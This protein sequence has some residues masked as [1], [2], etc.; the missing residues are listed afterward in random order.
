MATKKKSV[1]KK[2][3]AVDRVKL[4][5][6]TEQGRVLRAAEFRLRDTEFTHQWAIADW[7]LA[8]VEAFGK[9]KAYKA[10]M[11]ATGMTEQTLD[12]FAHTARK[13]LTRVKGVSFGHHRLV[14]KFKG[15][16]RKTQQK[17]QL[18]Y[19]KDNN[20]SVAEFDLYLKGDAHIDAQEKKTPTNPDVVAVKF[21]KSCDDLL[22][23][24]GLRK[25]LSSAP[26]L[27]EHRE[28]LVIKLKETARQLNEAVDGLSHQWQ[29]YLPLP[30]AVGF[31]TREDHET[32]LE[33]AEWRRREAAE[34]KSDAATAG[35][36]K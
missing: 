5:Q 16:D 10:A 11:K 36:G 3:T 17:K 20:L 33:N 2:A 7:M 25:L 6:W 18:N 12:Q 21:M 26:P 34:N 35:G 14:A 28:G 24:C 22:L 15:A 4:E 29:L 1:K 30:T 32:W 27:K 8:G 23:H 19:A 9:D 13:V 31:R